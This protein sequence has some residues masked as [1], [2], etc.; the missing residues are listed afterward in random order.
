MERGF[1]LFNEHVDFIQ[2]QPTALLSGTNKNRDIST[3]PLAHPFDRTG[4]EV[5][6]ELDILDLASASGEE[7]DEEEDDEEKVEE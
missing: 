1:C 2:F 5:G 7:D 3:G 6:G 4:G